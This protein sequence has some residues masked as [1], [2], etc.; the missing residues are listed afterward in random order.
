MMFSTGCIVLLV[1]DPVPGLLLITTLLLA[2]LFTV[3][4]VL[5]VILICLIGLVILSLIIVV[6]AIFALLA[7]TD[8]VVGPGGGV[9]DILRGFLTTVGASMNMGRSMSFPLVL[10]LLSLLLFKLRDTIGSAS[11]PD[12]RSLDRRHHSMHTV[13]SRICPQEDR[14]DMDQGGSAGRSIEHEHAGQAV[15][16]HVVDA[17]DSRCDMQCAAC[18]LAAPK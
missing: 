8:A 3:L 2:V 13:R 5:V 18:E 1:P 4:I 14:H 6:G 17:F 10:F 15:Q 7:T 11:Y 12:I 9:V 16:P